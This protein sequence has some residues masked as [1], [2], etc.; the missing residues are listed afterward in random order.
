MTSKKLENNSALAV[1]NWNDKTDDCTFIIGH[2]GWEFDLRAF[3]LRGSLTLSEHVFSAS[4]F[5]VRMSLYIDCCCT[6]VEALYGT[7]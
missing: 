6:S 7:W 3:F 2:R 1:K 5:I 4:M